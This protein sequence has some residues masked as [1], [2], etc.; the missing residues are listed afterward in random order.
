MY[1]APLAIA[2]SG[3]N[4]RPAP[5]LRSSGLDAGPQAEGAHTGAPV[6]EGARRFDPVQIGWL[7]ETTKDDLDPDNADPLAPAADGLGGQN[8]ALR[9]WA[10]GDAAQLRALLNDPDVWAHLPEDFPTALCEKTALD[11]IEIANRVDHHQVRAVLLGGQPVGQ[12]RLD[13]GPQAAGVPVPERAEAELSYWLGRARWGKGLGRAMAAGTVAR[14]FCNAPGLLRLVAKVRPENAPSRR[15]LERAGFSRI[16]APEGRGFGGWHWFGLRR[17]HWAR[18][19][20]Q[21]F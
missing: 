9:H 18:A 6:G 7:P 16:A 19:Q 20:A 12:V 8:M 17:Q 14:A 11:M 2:L 15:V 1:R 5:A 10:H 13:Y 21:S 4:R 3:S